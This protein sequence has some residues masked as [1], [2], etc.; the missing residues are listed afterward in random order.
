MGE[1]LSRRERW[2]DDISAKQLAHNEAT[3]RAALGRV[4]GMSEYAVRRPLP[5]ILPGLLNPIYAAEERQWYVETVRH[6]VRSHQRDCRSRGLR[7]REFAV[8]AVPYRWLI[9]PDRMPDIDGMKALLSR[10]KRL[11]QRWASRLPQD[12]LTVGMIEASLNYDEKW[13]RFSWAFHLHLLVRVTCSSD[14]QGRAAIAKA[15]PVK[16]N[17]AVGVTHPLHCVPTKETSGGARGWIRYLSK[18]LQLHIVYRRSVGYDEQTGKRLAA[19]HSKLTSE[20]LAPWAA[21]IA[22]LKGDDLMVCEGEVQVGLDGQGGRMAVGVAHLAPVRVP[23]RSG[24]LRPLFP[25]GVVDAADEGG[26]HDQRTL[27][28]GLRRAERETVLVTGAVEV[29]GRHGG[30]DGI[31]RSARSLANRSKKASSVG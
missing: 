8:T 27:R 10:W 14:R 25:G 5:K 22:E 19:R 18:G 26:R 29:D 13:G 6:L 11:T 30:P 20:E 1:R 17:D 9:E 23:G 31:W 4:P 15:V 3:A 28:R 16:R 2:L 7:Q 21:L 24:V 12:S